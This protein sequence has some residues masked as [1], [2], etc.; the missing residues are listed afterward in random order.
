MRKTEGAIVCPSCGKLIGVNEP[1]CPY[2]GVWRPGLYGW[3]PALQAL[4]G[5]RLDLIKL[6]VVACVAL[7]AIALLLQPEAIANPRGLLS[8]LSPG[9]RALVQLGRTGGD[10]MAFGWWWTLFTAIFLHGSLLHIFFNVL[11]I[12]DLG[13]VVTE[14]YGPARAFIIFMAAGAIGFLVSNVASGA[15]TIGASGSIFGLLAALIVYGRRHGSSMMSTQVWQWALVLFVMGFMLPA[16]NNWAH[17]GGFA[18]GWLAA[19]VMRPREHGREGTGVLVLALLLIAITAIGFVLSFTK[20]T[21]ILW[22]AQG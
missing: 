12:R 19:S 10:V 13:P 4:F 16:V 21:A 8:I 17:G 7:Y 20:V 1:K 5:Q 14:I 9:P 18:G 15:P 22:G 3:A 11:W 6:I 2:C